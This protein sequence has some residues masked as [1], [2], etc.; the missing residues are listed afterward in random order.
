MRGSVLA[1]RVVARR[2]GLGRVLFL[3]ALPRRPFRVS[4][5]FYHTPLAVL[6]GSPP[7]FPIVCMMILPISSG[8]T[9][10]VP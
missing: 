6:T 1:P 2:Y 5:T 9:R 8:V 7:A 4:L 3:S 10:V